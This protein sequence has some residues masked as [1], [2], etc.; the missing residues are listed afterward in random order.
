[1]VAA[2]KSLTPAVDELEDT[3]EKVESEARAFAKEIR[4]VRKSASVPQ[5]KAVK[6]G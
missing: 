2:R 5:M 3:A 4:V 6:A 1:V